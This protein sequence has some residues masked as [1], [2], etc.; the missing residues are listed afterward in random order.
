MGAGASVDGAAASAAD[1]EAQLAK[2][3]A[4]ESLAN[5]VE[6]LSNAL[7]NMPAESQATAVDMFAKCEGAMSEIQIQEAADQVLGELEGLE[8]HGALACVGSALTA[9]S[10]MTPAVSEAVTNALMA[11]GPHLPLI[12]IGCACLGGLVMALRQSK[13]NDKNVET[14]VLWSALATQ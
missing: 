4:Q 6:K 5:S 8:P 14:V 11:V 10:E 13:E 3:Q 2:L 12:G 9:C 1:M 7:E